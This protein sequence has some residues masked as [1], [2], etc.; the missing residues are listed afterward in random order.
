[1]PTSKKHQALQNI[2]TKYLLERGFKLDEIETDKTINIGKTHVIIDV[3]AIKKNK[4]LSI[5]IECGNCPADKIVRLQPFFDEVK[6][7]PY[8]VLESMKGLDKDVE[9]K[10]LK[11]KIKRLEEK[12]DTSWKEKIEEEKRKEFLL[13]LL[14]HYN[15]IPRD[16]IRAEHRLQDARITISKV[17]SLIEKY[18]LI[19]TEH[20]MNELYEKMKKGASE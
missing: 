10:R 12:V 7:F 16:S 4:S 18:D 8:D 20:R 13:A 19:E 1:M 11:K 17:L 6:V 9:I 15:V 3:V 14:L 5:A 2:A